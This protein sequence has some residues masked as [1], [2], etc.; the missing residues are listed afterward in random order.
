MA[1]GT[2]EKALIEQK[3]EA[4]ILKKEEK[5]PAMPLT[6]NTCTNSKWAEYRITTKLPER[7]SYM[8]SCVYNNK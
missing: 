5:S 8:C 2:K 7:R 3:E 4:K 6:I 1:T